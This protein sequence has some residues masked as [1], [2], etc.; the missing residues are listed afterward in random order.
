MA[1][2][3]QCKTIMAKIT[4]IRK[5][6]KTISMRSNHGKNVKSKLWKEVSMRNNGLH[7]FNFWQIQI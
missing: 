6:R 7:R 2:Q 4:K 5:L 3:F 1:K